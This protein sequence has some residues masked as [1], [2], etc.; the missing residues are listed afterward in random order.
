MLRAAY[1]S[2]MALCPKP[3]SNRRLWL[4]A[5]RARCNNPP[6]YSYA[7]ALVYAI[8]GRGYWQVGLFH[9]TLDMSR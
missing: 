7:L 2:A 1:F 9:T 6:L 3:F 8:F 4:Y 5:R